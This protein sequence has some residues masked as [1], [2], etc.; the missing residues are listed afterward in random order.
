LREGRGARAKRRRVSRW[1]SRGGLGYAGRSAH[2]AA[3]LG[4]AGD[5][6][7][8]AASVEGVANNAKWRGSEKLHR[9][10]W[11]GDTVE[12]AG[13]AEAASGGGKGSPRSS[14]GGCRMPLTT[15]AACPITSAP[16]TTTELAVE[17]PGTATQPGTSVSVPAI[18]PV[19]KVA[20]TCRGPR[21]AGEADLGTGRGERAL[22]RPAARHPAQ[23]GVERGSVPG[24]AGLAGAELHSRSLMGR[25][26]ADPG[27]VADRRGLAPRELCGRPTCAGLPDAGRGPAVHDGAGAPGFSCRRVRFYTPP[28]PTPPHAPLIRPK[29]AL[30]RSLLKTR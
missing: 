14:A 27:G 3:R 13:G 22:R 1:R 28:S 9:A 30:S 23:A 17:S 29:R 25:Q 26:R 19:H 16:G 8:A 18:V 2:R 5:L 20:E 12:T 24:T 7:V 10:G 15:L 21:A 4:V 6:A 11:G